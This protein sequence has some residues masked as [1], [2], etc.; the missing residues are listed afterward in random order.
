M[1]LMQTEVKGIEF[2]TEWQ[3][4]EA[5]LN[6]MIVPNVNEMN[7]YRTKTSNM[8]KQLGINIETNVWKGNR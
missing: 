7:F 6:S 2:H 1:Q 4:I 3:M 5:K 8:N